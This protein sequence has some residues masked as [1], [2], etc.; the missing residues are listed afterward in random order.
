MTRLGEMVV[1]LVAAGLVVACSSSSPAKDDAPTKIDG[2]GSSAAEMVSCTGLTPTATITTSGDAY[3]PASASITVG[4]T[5]EFVMIAN[6]DHNVTS[7][8][9]NLSDSFNMTDCVTFTEPGTYDFHCSVHLFT[10]SV[11]VTAN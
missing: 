10:G 8:T 2:A 1:G 11:T 7:S 9:P 4:Q 3:S 6:S 5:V